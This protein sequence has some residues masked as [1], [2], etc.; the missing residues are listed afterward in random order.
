VT[1]NHSIV[2]TLVGRSFSGYGLLVEFS[3]NICISC[4]SDG[5]CYTP[6][7]K[8]FVSHSTGLWACYKSNQPGRGYEC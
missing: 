3:W 8:Q 2:S 7:F 5:V 6:T 1:N 4:I